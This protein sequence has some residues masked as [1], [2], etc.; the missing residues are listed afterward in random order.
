MQEKR[1]D[2]SK[3]CLRKSEEESDKNAPCDRGRVHR[4][5]LG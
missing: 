2:D 4:R 3:D 1:R 5:L